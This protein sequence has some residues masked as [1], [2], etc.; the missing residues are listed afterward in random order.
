MKKCDSWRNAVPC[1]WLESRDHLGNWCEPRDRLWPI[2]PESRLTCHRI[3]ICSGGSRG[4][5]KYLKQSNDTLT[6]PVWR[7]NWNP[8]AR[9]SDNTVVVIGQ[10]EMTRPE[11]AMDGK[12]G[13]EAGE[14]T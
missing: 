2:H 7:R 14:L 5:I 6:Y 13:M 1:I 8:P 4:V 12:E 11:V 10:K 9:A 3:W